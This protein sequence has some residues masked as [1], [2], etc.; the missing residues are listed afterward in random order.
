MFLVKKAY[1]KVALRVHPDR[2][3][4]EEKEEATE[5]FKI[6]A[7]LNEVLSDKN[8]KALYDEQVRFKNDIFCMLDLFLLSEVGFCACFNI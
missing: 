6:L 8:K 2:V 4:E 1:Y 3:P 5:K 7:K